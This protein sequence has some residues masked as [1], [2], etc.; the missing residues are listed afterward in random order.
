MMTRQWAK[1][2]SLFHSGL[3]TE[4]ERSGLS[5]LGDDN[6]VPIL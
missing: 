3:K 4:L 5:N 2:L 1:P 6:N